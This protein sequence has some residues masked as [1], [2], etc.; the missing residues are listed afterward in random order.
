MIAKSLYWWEIIIFSRNLFFCFLFVWS[1]N[2]SMIFQTFN[3]PN[4]LN[5]TVSEF[6]RSSFIWKSS[7]IVTKWLKT[8]M[9]TTRNG[10]R[11]WKL[12]TY[13]F[14]SRKAVENIHVHFPWMFGERTTVILYGQSAWIHT[15]FS[16]EYFRI[17]EHI[18][19]CM[20]NFN[21][22]CKKFKIF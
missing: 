12:D 13:E 7:E 16:K 3:V 15:I 19:P 17:F 18:L 1:V 6:L 11:L 9:Q 21:H 10:E 5:M 14:S 4:L 8:F 22:Q 2:V 20:F